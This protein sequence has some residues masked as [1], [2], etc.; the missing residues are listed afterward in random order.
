MVDLNGR[1]V[2]SDLHTR[3][4]PLAAGFKAYDTTCCDQMMEGIGGEIG[5]Q[6]YPAPMDLGIVLE[7]G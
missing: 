3:E 7:R 5:L 1:I 2:S 6:P 4:R